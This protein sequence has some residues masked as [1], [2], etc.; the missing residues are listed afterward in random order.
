MSD[1]NF[2]LLSRLYR[3]SFKT[4]TDFEE[5]YQT[6]AHAAAVLC[7][8]KLRRLG[9]YARA[10]VCAVV[11]LVGFSRKNTTLITFVLS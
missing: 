2:L 7:D 11:V 5:S 1:G 10:P 3:H 4:L 8:C 6:Q 9:L